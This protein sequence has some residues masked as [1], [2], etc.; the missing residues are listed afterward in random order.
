MKTKF[1]VANTRLELL[2]YPPKQQHESLQA[3]DAADEYIIEHLQ[4]EENELNKP[5]GECNILLLNDNFGALACALSSFKPSF[6]SDSKVAAKGLLHNWQANFANTAPAQIMHSLQDVTSDYELAIMKLPKSNDFLV[7]LLIHLRSIMPSGTL[8]ISAGKANQISKNTLSLF[9]KHLG[10]TKTSLAK[11]K[12]RLIFTRV[13]KTLSSQSKFP[14]TWVVEDSGIHMVNHAN[15][16]ANSQLDIG[17]RLMLQHL[18]DITNR[19][20]VDLG[21]GNGVLGAHLLRD[22]PHNLHFVDESYMALQSAKATVASLS[23][24]HGEV[25]YHHSN[26]LEDADLPNISH[27][28]CNPPFHQQ[29]TITDHIAWQM[30]TDSYHCL[31]KGGEL[32]VVG[33]RHLDYHHKMKRLFGGYKIVASN[34]KFVVISSSKR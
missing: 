25:F 20:V 2:R 16:F 13:D 28:V 10:E 31:E 23:Q 18:P 5:L 26:C 17:A 9:E 34:K 7:E 8:L 29:N 19:N 14:K 33:N 12:S 21:C 15:T 32:R 6:Y 22:N 11:K 27:I 4:A 24:V 3:W 30:F 1:E